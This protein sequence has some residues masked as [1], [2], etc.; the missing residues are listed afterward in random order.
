MPGLL[1]TDETSVCEE[2][3]TYCGV[4][5]VAQGHERS[6]SVCKAEDSEWERGWALRYPHQ[7]LNSKSGG[8]II[9][10]SSSYSWPQY[11]EYWCS[12]LDGLNKNS[13]WCGSLT[14]S[15]IYRHL[16]HCLTNSDKWTE[17]SQ[18]DLCFLWWSPSSSELEV[19]KK[20]AGK[21]IQNSG[22]GYRPK[23]NRAAIMPE[24]EDT[25]SIG[26]EVGHASP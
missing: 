22:V 16:L 17:E 18:D 8:D 24:S 26:E 15:N 11:S 13:S 12:Q 20:K 1:L 3:L 19:T 9:L 10:L 6:L 4:S 7:I 14:W 2:G 5:W 25:R 23:R 21:W